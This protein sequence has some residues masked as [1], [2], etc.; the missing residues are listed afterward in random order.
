MGIKRGRIYNKIFNQED[1]DKVNPLNKEIMEDYKLELKQNQ[2]SEGTITQYIN[3]WKIIMLYIFRNID[4]KYIL[5][6][7]KKDFRRFSLWLSEELNMSNARANRIMSALRSL[8]DYCENDDDLDYEYNTAKKVKGLP[9]KDVRDIVFLTNEQI[10]K[11]KDELIKREEYQKATILMLAYDSGGRKNELFQ[12][13]K[14]SFYDKNKNYTN[15]VVGK[16]GKEF[17]LLYFDETKK[18]ADLYLQQ[19]GEDDI[20][21]MWIVDTGKIKKPVGVDMI[22]SWFIEMSN[23]LSEL[24]G[25]EIN[26]NVHSLR[27]SALEEYNSGN[28]YMCKKMNKSFS[29][30]ELQLLANHEN[31]ATTASYLRDKKDEVLAETFGIHI[32]DT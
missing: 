4:N 14:H 28:H 17:S 29:L 22:Y 12:T 8:L 9:K 18:C 15:K 1:W 21:N 19:R 13:M 20:D 25:K 31:Q 24:E 16:R 5:E 11:L 2:K 27:H 3:D 30:Q 6:L 32:K 23:I 10:F 7:T 26:F